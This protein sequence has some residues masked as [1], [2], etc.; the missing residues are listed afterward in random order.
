MLR[1]ASMSFAVMEATNVLTVSTR[2]DWGPVDMAVDAAIL[3]QSSTDTILENRTKAM[4]SCRRRIHLHREL[5]N[6][7]AIAAVSILAI[8]RSSATTLVAAAARLQAT[9]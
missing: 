8:Q 9:R 3:D 1:V 4:N 2:L 6:L 7:D 5:G